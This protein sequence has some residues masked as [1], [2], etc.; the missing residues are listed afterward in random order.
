M[1]DEHRLHY[2]GC[3]PICCM[4]PLAV[5]GLAAVQVFPSAPPAVL[6]QIDRMPANLIRRKA[7]DNI[8]PM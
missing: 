1:G 6:L 4:R 2:T 3:A 8:D 5:P 7:V